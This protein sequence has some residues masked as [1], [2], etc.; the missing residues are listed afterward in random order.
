P[1]QERAL[2]EGPGA[3]GLFDPGGRPPPEDDGLRGRREPAADHRSRRG[4]FRLD[5]E[6]TLVR[7]RRVRGP[8]P[9]PDPREGPGLRDRVPRAAEVPPRDDTPLTTPA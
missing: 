6:G 1:R 5:G 8:V 2:R 7:A 3:R 4:R 9:G